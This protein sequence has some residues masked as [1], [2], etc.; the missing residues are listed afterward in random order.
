MKSKIAILIISIFLLISLIG[1][2]FVIDNYDHTCSFS[3]WETT[4]EATCRNT[5]EQKRY[6]YFCFETETRIIKKS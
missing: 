6:C 1:C 5:G 4:V 3:S 2:D